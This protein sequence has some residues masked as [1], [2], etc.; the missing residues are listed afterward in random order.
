MAHISWYV[1]PLVNVLLQYRQ[2]PATSFFLHFSLQYLQRAQNQSE[3]QKNANKWPKSFSHFVEILYKDKCPEISSLKKNG[4]IKN[5]HYQKNYQGKKS[6]F[7]QFLPSKYHF[8]LRHGKTSEVRGGKLNAK[9]FMGN[10][11]QSLY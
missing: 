1:P 5:K 8:C 9:H 11:Q 2:I 6:F 10:C 3:F 4:A 7:W